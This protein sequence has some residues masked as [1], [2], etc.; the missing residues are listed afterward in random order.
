MIQST[1]ALATMGV[2]AQGRENEQLGGQLNSVNSTPPQTRQ[3]TFDDFWSG[4]RAQNGLPTKVV[5]Q[6]IATVP[7]QADPELQP[8]PR[9]RIGDIVE[10]TASAGVFRPCD[11]CRSTQFVVTKGKGPH[12][13]RLRCTGCGHG[14]VRWLSQRHLETA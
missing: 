6:P 8:D 7:P 3:R 12:A 5:R 13:G 10:C 1:S 9:Y 14:V 4:W 2:I 11:Q